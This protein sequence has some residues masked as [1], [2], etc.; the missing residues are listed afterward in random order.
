MR[1]VNFIFVQFE[2]FMK[3][4]YTKKANN[5]TLPTYSRQGHSL[6]SYS[7]QGHS[8]PSVISANRLSQ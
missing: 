6:P 1:L 2:F 5:G 3:I 4:Y 7:G 8:L